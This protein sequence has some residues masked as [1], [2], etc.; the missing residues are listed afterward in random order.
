M[1][2]RIGWLYGHEMNIYGDRGNVMCLAR[3]AEWRGIGAHV[4]TI[5][6]GERFDPCAHDVLFWGGGQDREQIAVAADLSGPKGAALAGAIEDG[7]PILAVCGGF[8]LLGHYYRP[9]DRP[10]L[11]GIGVLDVTSVAGDTRFIGNVVVDSPEFGVLV[12]FE[13]H[14]ARTFLGTGV[15]PLGVVRTG[16]GNNGQDGLEGARYRN[17]VGTYLHGSLLPKNPAVADWLIQTA[18]SRRYGERELAPLNDA[19]ERRAHDDVVA[20]ALA[21]AH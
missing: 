5:G 7:M 17:A 2:L 6:I 14:S 18:L 9:H 1:E 15:S 13:N 11:P 19:H 16:H 12:G 8:Q 10:E 4:T 21:L 3:R 20:R